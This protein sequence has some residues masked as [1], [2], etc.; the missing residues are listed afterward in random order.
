[1]RVNQRLG[2]ILGVPADI[3]NKFIPGSG[4][5]SYNYSV[6]RAKIN[7]ASQKRTT[8][9]LNTQ[10]P[11]MATQNQLTAHKAKAIVITCIDFR[12]RDDAVLFLNSINLNNNY[13]EFILAGASLGYN[14]TL[15]SAWTETLDKHIELAEQLHEITDV[16][17][18]DHMNCGAY[19][20]FYNLASID[21][22][23]E[24]TMHK[25]NFITFTQ[26]INGKYPNLK[27]STYLMDLDGTLVVL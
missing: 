27:V 24:I 23:T 1:M 14:Q 2:L 18:I 13:D 16:I 5:G 3:R 8:Q 15:F 22:A 12:L 20:I 26:T 19:K 11:G 25:A 4:V 21:R 10:I 9:I 17:V 6:T 7:R